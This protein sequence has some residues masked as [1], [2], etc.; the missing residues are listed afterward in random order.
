M[1]TTRSGFF[2]SGVHELWALR[3]GTQLETRPR[4]T[5]QSTFE[6]FPFPQ[7]G[8]EA[9][10]EIA[11]A[12]EALGTLRVGWLSPPGMTDADLSRLTLTN[13]YNQAPSWLSQAHEKLDR[14]V[15]AA[16]GW[17][18]PLDQDSVLTHLVALNRSRA[19][20]HDLTSEGGSVE[21]EGES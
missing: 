16:Y 5:P 10:R 7:A 9:R 12:A 2:Q 14:A 3:L 13:L 11:E 21:A 6:T 17:E 19:D 8:E 20:A 15:Q 4:Y 1:T 18:Y